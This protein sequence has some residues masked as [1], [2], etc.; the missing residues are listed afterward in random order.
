MRTGLRAGHGPADKAPVPWLAFVGGLPL[1]KEAQG[2]RKERTFVATGRALRA[3]FFSWPSQPM[4]S[5][6][7]QLGLWPKVLQVQS[8]TRDRVAV[9]LIFILN[10][11]K[12]SLSE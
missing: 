12:T 9:I 6:C 3:S 1:Q 2:N 7:L 11:I 5:S 4:F 10:R 8:D